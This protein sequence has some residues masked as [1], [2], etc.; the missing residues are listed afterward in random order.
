MD[1]EVVGNVSVNGI[2]RSRKL[3]MYKQGCSYRA[4][5]SRWNAPRSYGQARERIF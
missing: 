5:S 2:M 1:Y 4:D 3:P